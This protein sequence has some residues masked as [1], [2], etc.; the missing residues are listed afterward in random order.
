MTLSSAGSFILSGTLQS[1]LCFTPI[2]LVIH[3]FLSCSHFFH[4][5]VTWS[6][7]CPV[8]ASLLTCKGLKASFYKA[9]TNSL[10]FCKGFTY[11]GPFDFISNA[12][13]FPLWSL[14][15]HSQVI[16]PVQSPLCDQ[17]LNKEAHTM[18]L[19]VIL[20]PV[21]VS[22]K[23]IGY[24]LWV[25]HFLIQDFR[26]HIFHFCIYPTTWLIITKWSCSGWINIFIIKIS[27]KML[28]KA[29]WSL[30]C[31]GYL[32]AV[33]RAGICDS[34]RSLEIIENDR[35]KSGWFG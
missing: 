16:S 32:W 3:S 27:H 30:L 21:Y 2:T 26:F 31:K 13:P 25:L 34:E 14:P 23:T 5:W 15:S 6:A 24:F 20:F 9:F 1:H 7:K 12:S 10:V 19:S 11:F 28:K 18:P 17:W 22:G 4:L 33:D 35:L 29:L 8:N